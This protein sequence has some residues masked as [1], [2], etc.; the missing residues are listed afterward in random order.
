M[1]GIG[2]GVPSHSNDVRLGDVIISQPHDGHGVIQYDFRKMR[3]DGFYI[4]GFLNAPPDSLLQALSHVQAGHLLGENSNEAHLAIVEKNARFK[5]PKS[6][7]DILFKPTYDHATGEGTC[8]HCDKSQT[9]VQN[10]HECNRTEVHSGTIASGNLVMKNARERDSMSSKFKGILCFEIEAAGLLNHWPCLVIRGICDYA[11]SHKNDKWQP[12]AAGAAAAYAKQ[13]L[14][15][16]PAAA[17]EQETAV[18]I[19]PSAAGSGAPRIF[20]KA[21]L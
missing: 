12:Y 14:L 11:D 13:L 8:K 20:L 18:A 6:E 19:L 16:I 17:R 4:T 2:G 5:R 3:P 10:R 9:I 7:S 21:C 1:V 15:S